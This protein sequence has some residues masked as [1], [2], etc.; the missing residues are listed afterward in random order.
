MLTYA[1]CMLTYAD[2][3]GTPCWRKKKA[4]TQARRSATRASPRSIRQHT[5]AFV[6]IHLAY[7]SI[8]QHTPKC[9]ESVPTWHTSAYVSIRQHTPSTSQHR[10][11]YVSKRRSATRASL[12]RSRHQR[13][14]GYRAYVS[15]HQ[16]TSARESERASEKERETARERD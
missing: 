3:Y 1:R 9:D 7:V 15:I 11:A 14:E 2:V 4:R 10:P 16:H 8:R 5:S 12:P 13:E 6:S